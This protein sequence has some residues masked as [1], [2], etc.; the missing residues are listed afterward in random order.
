MKSGKAR[1]IRRMKS[2]IARTSSITTRAESRH[3]SSAPPP[4]HAGRSRSVGGGAASARARAT[5]KKPMPLLPREIQR[6]QRRRRR[7]TAAIAAPPPK[8]GRSRASIWAW[9]NGSGRR[10]RREIERWRCSCSIICARRSAT[11]AE[12]I[13]PQ[14]NQQEHS[15][16]ALL[17]SRA[18][19][20]SDTPIC[21]PEHRA[22]R[23]APVHLE[24]SGREIQSRVLPRY[25]YLQLYHKRR[26]KKKKK[27]A[28]LS[29]VPLP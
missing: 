28:L 24:D 17:I 6:A 20:Y 15:A 3:P 1:C 2:K 13:V 8:G 27:K 21:R 22:P 29:E 23:R 7:P 26:R 11:A 12:E 14:R 10:F 25:F 16:F 19:A 18:V 4:P 5:S 9:F